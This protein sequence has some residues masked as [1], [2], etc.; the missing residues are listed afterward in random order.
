MKFL[1]EIKEGVR[2]KR[3]SQL[4]PWRI[5]FKTK[6]FILESNI[7]NFVR[8]ILFFP[9][10]FYYY[11]LLLSKESSRGDDRKERVVAV[12]LSWK[13]C[14]NLP[15]VVY[16]LKKQSFID[17]VV[18][19]HNKPS[20]LRIP[21]CKNIFNEDNLGCVV[22]HKI[23]ATM[24]G[25]D[26]FVFS[27]DDL[28]LKEDLSKDVLP[29]IRKYGRESIIGF[30]GYELNIDHIEQAYTLGERKYSFKGVEPVDVVKGRF[31]IISKEGIKVIEDSKLDTEALL[32]EDDI[33]A[34]I[35]IQMKFNKPSYVIPVKNKITELP[36]FFALEK[37][38]KHKS[39][40][41]EAVNDG[42]ES[43]WS[44]ILNKNK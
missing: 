16:G 24:E 4:L 43:G 31:H 29:I 22:R 21:G 33:R 10:F 25:Y 37:R 23:A 30:Y 5:L 7:I 12:V 17:D 6:D 32:S 28:M 20:W 44:I 34:N 27:D 9:R 39:I 14:M 15:F 26:Y 2:K 40:R 36:A 19:I 42:L 13:R 3:S 41:D 11:F 38:K 35:A 1:N 18:V 8:Y